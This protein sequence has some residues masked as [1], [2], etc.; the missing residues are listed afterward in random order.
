MSVAVKE[1]PERFVFNHHFKN[2]QSSLV[3]P[4]LL[5]FRYMIP[6]SLQLKLSA[7]F[8]ASILPLAAE[9][10]SNSITSIRSGDPGAISSHDVIW[11]TPGKN[12]SDSMPIGNG[13]LGINLWVEENGDLHFYLGRNDTFSEVSQLC[14]VGAVRVSLSPNPFVTGAPF[15]Q[16]LKL[17]DGICEITAGP[18]D[19]LV[20]LQVF[21]DSASPVVHLLG[22]STQPLFV[23]AKVESWRTKPQEVSDD[24]SWTMAQAPH[25]PMQAADIF[26]KA[27]K[28]S[29]SWYHRNENS[30]AFEE[31]IR[32][33]SLETI[34]DTLKDPL[35]QRTFGGWVT[36]TGF[37]STDDRTL[38]TPQPVADFHLRVAS[39]C[40]QTPTAEAWMKSAG[41]I[42]KSA[43]DGQAAIARTSA[44]WQ[45]F[46]DRSY[47]NT[48]IAPVAGIGVPENAH[49]VR[50][51]V[52][53]QGGNR[54]SGTIGTLDLTGKV[55]PPEKIA[56]LAKSQPQNQP[57]HKLDAPSF[58]NGLSIEGW[59]KPASGAS[60]RILDKLTV[61]INDGFLFDIQPEGSLRLIVGSALITSPPNVIKPGQWQ[62]VAATFDPK[63]AAMAL[64][65]D[66]APVA[67]PQSKATPD[68]MTV[69][70]AHTL[71]RYMQACAARS[72]Y[73]IK[74]NGSIFT[75]EPTYLGKDGNPDWRRWGDCHWWQNVRMPYH[76]MQAV[77]DFDLMMPLFDTFE[78]IRPYAEARTKLYFKAEGCFFTETM[79]IWGTY[80][81]RDY[82]WD[83]TGK[84]P[85]EMVNMWVRHVWNQGLELTGLMLDYYDHTGDEIF[86]K[87]RLLPMATSVLKYFDTRFRKDSEGRIIID[88]TQSVETYW[89]DVINDTPNVAGLNDVSTRLCNLPAKLTNPTQRKFFT[90]M[91]AATPEIPMED[92][93]LDGKTVR[94]IAVAQKYNP[95]RNNV[96]NPE[97]FPIW[98]FRIFGLDRPMLEEARNAYRLRGS[99]NDVGWGYDGNAAPLLGMTD[100]AARILKI[101]IAN[102]N[103]AYRW[104]ATWGPNFDWLPDQ[105]HGGNLMASI[106]YMLL[107]HDGDK[108]LLMPAWPKD[109]DVSFKLHAPRQTTVELVYRGGK[110]EKL[111]VSPPSRRKDIALPAGVFAP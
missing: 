98:P 15:R 55:L 50:I 71:Q 79:T 58:K 45:T 38:V 27:A 68:N 34:R 80:A 96:E 14:K 67:Q 100:E 105:C 77:G 33:Q 52:D 65:V 22:K 82:G 72:I 26:P 78:R 56:G 31:T 16:H 106:N 92:A 28:H 95:K 11:N 76:A 102:S 61:G 17:R 101:K 47:V 90:H 9:T 44:S 51:G 63:T 66:G 41:S 110:I 81:N 59:I 94:R 91:K 75:V 69:G 4:S 20:S 54:F 3:N 6:S 2:Q 19:K 5:I 43:A 18:P 107:Q 62:H 97:L 29:V 21:V 32:V 23:T 39:P 108:I 35:L 85:G 88:P 49:P 84:K 53:S 37:E 109:W 1:K 89:T 103:A 57:P 24:S 12:S 93:Q 48:G 74:F 36:G 64:Y 10:V 99:H 86:L 87:E 73:P 83:R 25:K 8:Y 46:W 111:E 7:L 30:F 40:Q 70:K 13:E 104:P 60:A 42:A